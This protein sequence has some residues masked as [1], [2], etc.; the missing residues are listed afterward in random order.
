MASRE[1]T[2]LELNS[3]V[4]RILDDGFPE[5]FWIR[6]VITGLRRQSARG[7]TYFQLADPAPDGGQSPAVVDCALY[8]GDRAAIA[9]EAGR[10]GG[11]LDLENN[12]EVRILARVNF[13]ERAGR[14]QLVMKGFDPHF[15]GS[16]SAIHLQK[17]LSKLS[18]EGILEENGTL[19]FPVLPLTIGL[20]TA[21]DSAAERDFVK[22]LEESGYPFR[23][24]VAG[25]VMQ[26]SRTAESVCGAFNSLLSSAVCSELDA[27][28]LTR[29]GG[30]QTDLAW[31]N[32]EEIARTI[33]QVPWPVISAIGHEIDSTLPDFTAHTRAKTPTHAATIL[34]DATAAFDER[35]SELVRSLA[36]TFAPRIS[37]ERLRLRSLRD[38]A[39][40]ALEG[41]PGRR[42]KDIERLSA[43]MELSAEKLLRRMENELRTMEEFVIRR[44]PDKMLKLGWAL[45]KDSN[46]RIRRNTMNILPGSRLWVRMQD[47][48]LGV[49]VEERRNG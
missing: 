40:M 11:V 42:M 34:V 37:A 49:L 10:Q 7:H 18:L 22:T 26:G 43:R 44:D 38:R 15:A 16:S 39:A 45:V 5:V 27:V 24:F 25:A 41:I 21:R 4:S 29:G 31:F 30:S 36:A 47:A 19:P 1:Y 9:I 48:E 2:I 6:G 3:T 13:W 20:V 23:V 35:L 46:G 28:V 33:A 17:L 12:T 8:A 32:Q 14:F